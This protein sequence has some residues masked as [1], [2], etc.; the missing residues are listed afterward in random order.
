MP[1]RAAALS[2]N[3]SALKEIPARTTVAMSVPEFP[4]ITYDTTIEMTHEKSA[5]ALIK[6]LTESS[7][8]LESVA[9]TDLYGGDSGPYK[10]TIRCTYRSDSKTLTEEEA[11]KE[12]VVA[13]NILKS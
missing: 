1:S 8:L 3:V 6:K 5:G 10:L 11:K 12:Y 4:S 7:K 9:I 2:L 13:E